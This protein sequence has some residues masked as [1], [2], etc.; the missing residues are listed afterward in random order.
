MAPEYS[1]ASE[2]LSP[3]VPLYAVDCDQDSNKRLCSEQGVQ[4]FPT[5][6]LYPRGGK[7]KSIGFEGGERIANNFFHWTSRNIPHDVKKLDNGADVITWTDS[8]SAK[9]QAVLLSS[10]KTIPL[11]WKALGNKYKDSIDFAILYD[12]SGKAAV[13][14]GLEDEPN[15]D[16]KVLI[17][18]AGSSELVR[19]EG[20]L[21]Y[22]P[23]DKHLKSVADGTAKFPESKQAINDDHSDAQS[24]G[25]TAQVVVDPSNVSTPN[26]PTEEEPTSPPLSPPSSTQPLMATEAEPT[27]VPPPVEPE[28]TGNILEAPHASAATESSTVSDGKAGVH[29]KDEL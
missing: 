12:K 5:I 1:K 23:L 11:M 15:K 20:R 28:D 25:N 19:Y 22:A 21:K 13:K 6:K 9:P 7:S 18:P 17:S 24:S 14:L 26:I 4:G 27:E 16:S 8:H 10:A 29:T 3:M 2:A